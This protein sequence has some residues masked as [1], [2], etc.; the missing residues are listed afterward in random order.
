MKNNI[1][2]I[3][4]CFLLLWSNLDQ[5]RLGEERACFIFAVLGSSL[6]KARARTQAGQEPGAKNWN[7]AR[8]SAAHWPSE[9]PVSEQ[10][11]KSNWE[12]LL[13]PP[14][15]STCTPLNV[16]TQR[17]TN[18]HATSTHAHLSP[19][20]WECEVNK[21]FT[22]FSF[23]RYQ[24]AM[25]LGILQIPTT[26]TGLWS[27]YRSDTFKSTQ[28]SH[29]QQDKPSNPSQWIC[30]CAVV[31][32]RSKMKEIFSLIGLALKSFQAKYLK[33]TYLVEVPPKVVLAEALKYQSS[34]RFASTVCIL[35]TYK[36][37]WYQISRTNL[38]R[39][40]FSSTLEA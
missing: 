5:E 29:K 13:K 9:R 11:M 40:G 18:T 31:R 38:K 26:M 4:V 10:K 17:N 27:A 1:Y 37:D 20:Y 2:T 28:L 16:H 12:R 23:F 25:G 39:H 30:R 19:V 35:P 36:L 32:T 34:F 6:T 14:L 7:E 33:S 22:C 24:H 3:W 21:W 8:G 15:L